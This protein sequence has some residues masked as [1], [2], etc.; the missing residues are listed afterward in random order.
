MK[1]FLDWNINILTW[2]SL[3]CSGGRPAQAVPARGQAVYQGAERERR[4]LPTAG[5]T[6]ASPW[7][8]PPAT[9]G[10]GSRR[11]PS[12]WLPAPAASLLSSGLSSLGQGSGW[13]WAA[14]KG[15]DQLA[16]SLLWWG[17]GGRGR[18]PPVDLSPL[19]TCWILSLL[20]IGIRVLE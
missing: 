6:G 1:Y 2:R 3:Q 7:P 17:G 9:A 13:G 16:S 10:S 18:G 11:R 15:G 14:W 5:W 4:L 19:Q 12:P 20:L 8:G